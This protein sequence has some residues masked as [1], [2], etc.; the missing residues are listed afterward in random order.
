MKLLNLEADLA[1]L[2]HPSSPVPLGLKWR[3]SIIALPLCLTAGVLKF[4]S[5]TLTPPFVFLVHQGQT[6]HSAA[7]QLGRC[8]I[9]SSLRC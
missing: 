2:L 4:K 1:V 8:K 3:Y 7:V 6:V 9:Q 5:F